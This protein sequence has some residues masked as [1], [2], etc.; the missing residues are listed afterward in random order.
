ME[1]AFLPV[2]FFL[3]FLLML[4]TALIVT[5]CIV[6]RNTHRY[7]KKLKADRKANFHK[8]AG[9]PDSTQSIKAA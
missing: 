7:L 3:T 1:N 2:C 6:R 4:I 8:K 9:H 5:L